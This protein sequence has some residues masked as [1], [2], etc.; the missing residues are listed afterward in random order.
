MSFVAFFVWVLSYSTFSKSVCVGACESVLFFLMTGSSSIRFMH[1]LLL[2]H[3]SVQLIDICSVSCFGGCYF[4]CCEGLQTSLCLHICFPFFWLLLRH[5]SVR[6]FCLTK[7]LPDFST[8]A[9]SFYMSTSRCIGSNFSIGLQTLVTNCEVVLSS[10]SVVMHN[11]SVFLHVLFGYL[12][13][14][15][16]MSTLG[17]WPF[18]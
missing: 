9:A 4:C 18:F 12:Y 3:P 6:W 5:G 13:I 15:G 8:G 11:L 10:L 16:E 2:A 7:E 17:L 14:S 1:N